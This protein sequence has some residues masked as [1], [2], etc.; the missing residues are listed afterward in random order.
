MHETESEVKKMKKLPYGISDYER[1][2]ENDYYYVDKTKYIEKLENLAEP[3][4]IFLRPRKFGKTLFTSTLENYYDI[5]KVD[6][7]DKKYKETYKSMNPDIVEMS[8]KYENLLNKYANNPEQ[9]KIITEGEKYKTLRSSYKSLNN[10]MTGIK[11]LGP[12]VIFTTIYRFVGPVVV[13]PFANWIS[14]KIEPHNKKQAA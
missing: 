10:K 6:K 13:T 11:L 14:E 1:I 7:F 2:Q 9:L 3:Y 5:K 4:I 12:I 8:K